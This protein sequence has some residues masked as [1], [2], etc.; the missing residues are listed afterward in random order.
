MAPPA[1]GPHPCSYH[2]TATRRVSVLHA[3]RHARLPTPALVPSAPL[4]ASVRVGVAALRV[5][6]LRTV[7]SALGVIIGVGAMV[8]VLSLSDCVEREVRAQLE[9]DGRLHSVLVSPR[10]EDV[11]DGQSIPRAAYPVF[12]AADARAL[13]ADLAGVGT[14]Y[15]GV[16]GPALVAA[17]S[18]AAPRRARLRHAR[19]RRR[20]A[21]ARRRGRALLRGC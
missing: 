19:Q 15:F 10:I 1:T 13:A 20:A 2:T 11:I 21:R 14:V 5:N 4:S 7:L 8:S 17:D 3:T 16:S 18:G 12:T 9:R 6:P